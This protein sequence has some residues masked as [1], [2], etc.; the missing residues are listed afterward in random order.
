MAVAALAED[1]REDRGADS[2][3][4][5]GCSAFEKSVTNLP[6]L[7]NSDISALYIAPVIW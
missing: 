4:D 1:W 6:W 7:V 5:S 3:G 2:G